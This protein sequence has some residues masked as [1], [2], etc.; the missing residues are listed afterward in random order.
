[1]LAGSREIHAVSASRSNVR[2]P[3]D[4][5]PAGEMIGGRML[6]LRQRSRTPR[7]DL[8]ARLGDAHRLAEADGPEP[9]Q[10]QVRHEVQG[11]VGLEDRRG[12]RV[13]ADAAALDPRQE[14]DADAV[15]GAMQEM[16]LASG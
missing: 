14:L 2:Q 8:A 1:M 6:A 11:H 10:Q 16:P 9:R 5:T 7:E 3:A 12:A 15:A 4:F 13:E